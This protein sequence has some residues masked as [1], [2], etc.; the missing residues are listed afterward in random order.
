MRIVPFALDL[1]CCINCLTS[2][3]RCLAMSDVKAWRT[4]HVKAPDLNDTFSVSLQLSPDI[5]LPAVK[6]LIVAELKK[7][8]HGFESLRA[9]YITLKTVDGIDVTEDLMPAGEEFSAVLELQTSRS[10]LG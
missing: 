4:F 10:L 7:N 3:L 6:E 8:Y 1:N 5:P 2:V 9:G